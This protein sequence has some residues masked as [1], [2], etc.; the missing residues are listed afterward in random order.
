MENAFKV[1]PPPLIFKKS[2]KNQ[3]LILLSSF[4]PA[5]IEKMNFII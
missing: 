2:F 1:R 3:A 5:S 4:K